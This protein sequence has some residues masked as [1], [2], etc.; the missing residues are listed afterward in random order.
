MKR[1]ASEPGL[2]VKKYTCMHP[3]CNMPQAYDW[4]KAFK[5]D[6]QLTDSY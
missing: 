3:V 6:N 4:Y 1:S 5:V 2:S